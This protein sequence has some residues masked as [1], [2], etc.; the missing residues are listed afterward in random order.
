MQVEIY[1]ENIYIF[2]LTNE[3]S[4]LNSILSNSNPNT[5]LNG[6]IGLQDIEAAAPRFCK[7][8][9]MKVARL[10]ALRTGRIYPPGDNLDANFC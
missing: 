10:S 2:V 6:P 7:N 1:A 3:T 9:H 8:R 5:D 4:I